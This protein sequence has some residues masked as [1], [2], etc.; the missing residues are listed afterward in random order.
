[1][2]EVSSTA[3]DKGS[4]KNTRRA[5]LVQVLLCRGDAMRAVSNLTK[6]VERKGK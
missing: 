5:K 3:P 4:R 1:M 2:N 6:S